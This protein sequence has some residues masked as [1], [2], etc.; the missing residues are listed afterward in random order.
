M[1]F[2]L[3]FLYMLAIYLL[4]PVKKP[5]KD[6]LKVM[7]CLQLI[8]E[9]LYLNLMDHQEGEFIQFYITQC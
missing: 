1:A 5:Y 2:L 9:L 7:A 6:F 4:T 8:P 3:Q